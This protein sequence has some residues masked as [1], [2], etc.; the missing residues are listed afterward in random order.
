MAGLVR[1][2]AEVPPHLVPVRVRGD[3]PPRPGAA[4]TSP[5]DRPARCGATIELVLRNGRVLRVPEA[6]VPEVLARLA[7]ALDG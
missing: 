5:A 1:A 4:A 3:P 7:A 6:I 2:E